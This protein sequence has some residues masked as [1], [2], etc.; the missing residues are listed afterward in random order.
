M[1]IIV[2]LIK[3]YFIHINWLR[4][5]FKVSVF[6]VVDYLNVFVACS[7][8]LWIATIDQS[9]TIWGN[10]Y[11]WSVVY[12]SQRW[13]FCFL[14]RGAFSTFATGFAGWSWIAERMNFLGCISSVILVDWVLLQRKLVL[15]IIT[16]GLLSC[17][18]L[19]FFVESIY[20]SYRCG[21][22]PF[23]IVFL[24]GIDSSCAC[25]ALIQLYCAFSFSI[26]WLWSR[27]LAAFEIR[28]SILFAF[29]FDLNMKVSY[30]WLFLFYWLF[31]AYFMISFL[32]SWSTGDIGFFAL[33]GYS[34]FEVLF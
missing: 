3:P 32:T 4:L 21:L 6:P 22:F 34:S 15:R 5:F 17:Y 33:S 12:F 7:W 16:R 31:F 10:V 19:L 1:R 11:A 28:R 29:T 24:L 20:L 30:W 18:F 14:T 13:S 26:S 27:F 23:Y 9:W 25:L 2:S 8:F